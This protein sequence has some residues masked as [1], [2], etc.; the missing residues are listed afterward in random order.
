MSPILI[1][2]IGV[3][4]ILALGW[5]SRRPLGRF[6]RFM[7]SDRGPRTDTAEM[8]RGELFQSGRWF[9]GLGAAFLSASVALFVLFGSSF[10]ESAPILYIFFV[11]MFPGFMGV[12]AGL[13]LVFRGFVRSDEPLEPGSQESITPR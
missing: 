2:A 1:K 9:L 8:S 13:Y 6:G 10:S 3:V 11:L 5:L 12:G 4:I 7:F